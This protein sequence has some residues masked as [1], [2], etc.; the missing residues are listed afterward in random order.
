MNTLRRNPL[1]KESFMSGTRQKWCA[2][3]ILYS[4]IVL[5][6]QIIYSVDPSPYMNFAITIGSLFI[7]GGSVDSVMKIQAAKSFKEKE[8][9]NTSKTTEE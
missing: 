2:V 7:L 1:Y 5:G 9:D 6:T 3:F 8:L 4:F